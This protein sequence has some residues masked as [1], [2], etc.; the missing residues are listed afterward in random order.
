MDYVSELDLGHGLVRVRVTG[1]KTPAMVLRALTDAV[2]LARAHHLS[3][4]LV[5]VRNSTR[6]FTQMDVLA[7]VADLDGAELVRGDRISIISPDTPFGDWGEGVASQRG[8]QLRVFATEQEAEAWL[9][10][11]RTPGAR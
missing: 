11:S 6:R 2:P 5:D 3:R 4:F 8:W 10:E 1:P 9:L 7:F